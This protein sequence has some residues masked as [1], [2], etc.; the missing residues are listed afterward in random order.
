MKAITLWQPWASLVCIKL[1]ETRSWYTKYRGPLAIH[2]AKTFPAVAR[3]LCWREP[4]LKHLLKRKLLQ[5]SRAGRYEFR[6][7]LP[8]GAIVSTTNLIEC[9]LI[10]A[11]GLYRAPDGKSFSGPESCTEFY[12]PLPG[13]PERSFGD[14][15]P[16]RYA[17][18]LEDV[19][20]LPEPIPAKGR[21]RL[22]KWEVP[23]GVNIP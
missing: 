2:A 3:D 1:N 12:A 9:C 20:Q 8:L 15:T 17:W 6:Y 14:Y 11:D 4:F 13:E 10:K 7:L 5:T 22:W 16:G 23:E 19:R 18:I 21:Q